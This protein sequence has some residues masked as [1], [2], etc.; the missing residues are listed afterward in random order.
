M[1][2]SLLLPA[3]PS[4]GKK[5]IRFHVARRRVSVWKSARDVRQSPEDDSLK[6]RGAI[7]ALSDK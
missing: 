7:F 3:L 6:R 1:I 4:S 2:E 5:T